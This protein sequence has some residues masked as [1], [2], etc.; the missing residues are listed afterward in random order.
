MYME[1]CISVCMSV[2]VHGF[3]YVCVYVCQCECVQ[4]C[5]YKCVCMHWTCALLRE[6]HRRAIK[7]QGKR[8]LR[9]LLRQLIS[10]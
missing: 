6:V 7:V 1:A 2:S 3:E 9:F 5:V 10:R 8:R 4:V